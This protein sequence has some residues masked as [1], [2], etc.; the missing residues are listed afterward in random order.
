MQEKDAARILKEL[1][2][3]TQSKLEA[4]EETEEYKALDE[5]IDKILIKKSRSEEEQKKLDA[6]FQEQEKWGN[7]IL[8][9]VI[10]FLEENSMEEIISFINSSFLEENKI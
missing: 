6:L 2:S 5:E 8:Q 3:N 9:E 7:K 10:S 4:F 1:I